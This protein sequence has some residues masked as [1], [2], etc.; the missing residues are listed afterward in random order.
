[1]PEVLAVS[2]GAGCAAELATSPLGERG[3]N[4][5]IISSGSGASTARTIRVRP[6]VRKAAHPSRTPKA[7]HVKA[8]EELPTGRRGGEHTPQAHET[9][10]RLARATLLVEDRL[11]GLTF[12]S[13]KNGDQVEV[14]LSEVVMGELV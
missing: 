13:R 12:A 1:L 9:E 3:L 6:R 8:K 11:I 10:S 2:E 4:A 7:M 5:T 14:E